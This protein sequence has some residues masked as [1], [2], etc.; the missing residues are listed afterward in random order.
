[1]VRVAPVADVTVFQVVVE[2]LV[3]VVETSPATVWLNEFRSKV[4]RFV[5]EACPRFRIVVTGRRSLLVES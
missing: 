1:M 4:P 2:T 5:E 3:P